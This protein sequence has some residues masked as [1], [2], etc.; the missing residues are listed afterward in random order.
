MSARI[1][2]VDGLYGEEEPEAGRKSLRATALV[3]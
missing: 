1:F 3:I 2:S